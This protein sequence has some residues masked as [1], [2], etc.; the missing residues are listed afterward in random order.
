M[1]TGIS[2]SNAKLRPFCV[3]K[4]TLLGA[5]GMFVAALLSGTLGLCSVRS[6]LNSN[7]LERRRTAARSCSS[8]LLGVIVEDADGA[9]LRPDAA[10]LREGSTALLVGPFFE[11]VGDSYISNRRWSGFDVH[12]S[13][14]TR[15]QQ[16]EADS[17]D[18]TY[19]KDDHQEQKN[20]IRHGFKRALRLQS[21]RFLS[22][23]I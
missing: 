18:Q 15:I 20:Y 2:R 5:H 10:A 11:F 23:Y 12:L 22:R 17:R 19:Q 3:T 7:S 1:H 8:H 9:Q 4:G 6:S 14:E 16:E 13:Q 21:L